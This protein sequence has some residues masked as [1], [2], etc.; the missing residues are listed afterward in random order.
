MG[1]T[2]IRLLN[3]TV[4]KYGQNPYLYEARSNIEY[5]S[6]TFS[7]V[8]E[9]SIRFAAGLIA[10]GIDAGERVSLMSEGKNNWVIGE[11][12]VLHAGA[13]CVPLS[14]KL[15]TEHDITFRINHSDSVMVLASNQQIKSCPIKKS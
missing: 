11:L 12:G 6:L 5:T 13:V 14:V 2:I 7:E 3:E 10:M 9:M 8:K 1:K 15:E 4:E